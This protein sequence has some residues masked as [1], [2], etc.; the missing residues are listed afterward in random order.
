MVRPEKLRG[1]L[2]APTPEEM[3]CMAYLSI[4]H[5]ATGL[6][7]YYYKD[8][9]LSADAGVRWD[10]VKAI[11]RDVEQIAPILLSSAAAG[12][13]LRCDNPEVDWRAIE[14]DGKTYLIAVNST[15]NLQTAWIEGF[16]KPIQSVNVVQGDALAAGGNES[17]KPR[18]VLLL[19]ALDTLVVEIE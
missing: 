12:R 8:I 7:V 5:G 10:A 14:R 19:D 3:R 17:G 4:A 9:K 16:S 18:L 13:R 2:R 1:P 15:R 11:A 6:V